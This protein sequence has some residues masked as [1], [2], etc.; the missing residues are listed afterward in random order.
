M[1]EVAWLGA[2]PPQDKYQIMLGTN[3]ADAVKVELSCLNNDDGDLDLQEEL[4][5]RVARALG[6]ATA[7][8]VLSETKD[9]KEVAGFVD[10]SLIKLPT[11]AVLSKNSRN[12]AMQSWNRCI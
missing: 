1:Q 3:H 2:P 7:P 12:T 9:A 6:L 4:P 5:S 8:Y 11:A 10:V